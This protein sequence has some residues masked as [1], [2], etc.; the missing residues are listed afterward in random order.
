MTLGWGCMNSPK[1]TMTAKIL[2]QYNQ[3][4]TVGNRTDGGYYRNIQHPITGETLRKWFPESNVDDDLNTPDINE[5]IVLS[6][7]ECQVRPIV[8]GGLNSQGTTERWTS[9]GEFQ[10]IDTLE[11]QMPAKEIL[12]SRDRVYDIKDSHGNILWLEEDTGTFEPTI[13]D[14]SSFAPDLD[15]FGNQVGWF[16]YLERSA[17]QTLDG[18]EIA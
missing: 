3:K 7:I 8:T 16:G 11:I 14:I 2:R 18:V 1:Y 17:I 10:K 12:T 5:S 9:K 15:P 13:F 6:T 4:P